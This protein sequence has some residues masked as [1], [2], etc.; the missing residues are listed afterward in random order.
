MIDKWLPQNKA[1][2]KWFSAARRFFGFLCCSPF[3]FTRG[4]PEVGRGDDFSG[5]D[6]GGPGKGGFLNNRLFSWIICHLYYTSHT[7][8]SL[9]KHRSVYEHRILFRKPPLLGPPLSFAKL[10]WALSQVWETKLRRGE[11]VRVVDRRRN[12]SPRPRPRKF[13]KLAF[14]TKFSRSYI[15]YKNKL[16]SWGSSWGRGFRFYRYGQFYN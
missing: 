4:S 8:S 13:S 12:G 7:I 5:K 11:D 16:A 3:P 6:K 14:L 9:H 15:L 1:A 2:S 10:F